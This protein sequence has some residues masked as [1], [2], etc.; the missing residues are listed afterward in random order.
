MQGA[1]DWFSWTIAVPLALLL[2]YD[3]NISL[4]LLGWAVLAGLSAGLGQMLIGSI[5]HLYQGRYVVGSFDEILGVILTTFFVGGVATFLLLLSSSNQFPRST[6][7]IATGIATASMLG[8]RFLWRSAQQQRA[9]QRDGKRTLIFGA[10]D[11]GSQIVQL[12]LSDRHSA[13]QPIGFIDDDPRKYHLRRSGIRVLG[14]STQLEEICSTK[15]VDTVLI[16]IAGIQAPDLLTLDQRLR[17]LG[18]N[19]TIIPTASEIAGGAVKL[20]DISDVTEEDLMGR[21]P[22]KTDEVKIT[23]F[24]RGKRIL[25]TGAGGSIGS[26][27][28][29]QIYRYRPEALFLLDRDESALLQ[30]QLTLDGSGHL[31]SPNLILADIRD[32][33]RI[34]EVLCEIQPQILFH[35]AALKHLT[36]LE[37]NPE[38]AFKTNVRGTANLLQ[39]AVDHK[40]T[41]FVNISTDKAADPTSVLGKSKLLTEQLTAGVPEDSRRTFVSVRFGNVL[42]SR[43][44]VIDTFRYQIENGGPVTVT[45]ESVTRYF[46]TIRE[47]VHL[48]LQAAVI[49]QHGETLILDMGSPI[50]IADLAQH[51]IS[52]S[53]RNISIEY[54]GLRPGEKKHEVLI[55]VQELPHSTSHELVTSSRVLA[56]ELPGPTEFKQ[57]SW[58][59]D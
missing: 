31:M 20:G 41:H 54:T 12:M 26:E 35:A 39:S 8:A 18:V 13:F 42:G 37:R 33:D 5:F 28:V 1:W 53:G 29:R 48:V 43:G 19:V 49:G 17:P 32:A 24:I 40:V 23:E 15:D 22:I 51:M 46:M 25:V 56:I 36:L 6:F 44:S 7:I 47:A 59:K 34:S 9:L 55:S 2:R 45:D 38:E 16:A 58:A 50:R 27:L 57:T 4:Q 11:A 14:D 3:F 21:R 30:V 10:G 52:R